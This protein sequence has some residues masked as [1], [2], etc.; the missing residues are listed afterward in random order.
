MGDGVLTIPLP[1]GGPAVDFVTV[2]EGSFLMGAASDASSESDA[3]PVHDVWLDAFHI[4]ARPVTNEQ[5]AWFVNATGY[6]T[7]R[8]QPGGGPPYWHQYAQPGRERHP[9]ICVNWV[10]VAA[11]AVWA[12]CRM[13]T[14]AEWERAARRRRTRRIPVGRRCPRRP[15]QLAGRNGQTG[16]IRAERRGLWRHAG[17]RV[18][19]ERLRAA[20]HERQRVGVVLGRLLV[21]LLRRLPGAESQGPGGGRAG[22]GCPPRRMDR[23]RPSGSRPRRVPSDSWRLLGEQR[24][25]HALLRTCARARRVSPEAIGWRRSPRDGPRRV[26]VDGARGASQPARTSR[27]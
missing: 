20:R 21:G 9:V 5:F 13:P 10:D 2:P 11:F 23:R 8:E 27:A 7:T 15:V 12:R 4:A 1:G 14:E 3:R 22:N 18:S 17:R 16:R 26:V 6:M 19:R 24:V 25:G